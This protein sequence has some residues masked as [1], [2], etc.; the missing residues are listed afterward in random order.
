MNEGKYV[1][2][3]ARDFAGLLGVV[4]EVYPERVGRK[5]RTRRRTVG[6]MN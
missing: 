5:M 4:T 3:T 1:K 6:R 2:P